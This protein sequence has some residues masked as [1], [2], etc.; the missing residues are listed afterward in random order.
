MENVSTGV[1]VVFV[2]TTITTLWMFYKAFDKNKK[3]VFGILLWAIF[4]GMLGLSGFYQ[5]SDAMPPRIVFLLGPG[6]LFVLLLFFS[7][8]GK[9][10]IDSLNIKWL[11]ILHTIR[12][13]VE[14]VLYYV[15]LSG[16]IPV[17]MTFEGYNLDII[18]GI[19]APIAYYLVFVKK[20]ASKKFLILWN[21]LCLG[22]LINILVIAVLSA[23]TPVQKLAFDQPNIGVAFF[24]FVWL[25]SIIVPIVLLSHLASIRQLLVSTKE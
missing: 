1:I 5:Q 17:Y 6:I 13:P 3:L 14:I 2:L 24:P 10:F 8:K 16:L 20:L 22:L 12:I 18:S 7:K 11:T 4:V 9:E 15:F 25:P 19:T 21:F 23:Q